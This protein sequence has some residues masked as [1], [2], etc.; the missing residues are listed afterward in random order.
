MPKEGGY[1]LGRPGRGGGGGLLFLWCGGGGWGMPR[2]RPSRSEGYLLGCVG[3]FGNLGLTRGGPSKLWRGKS[4]AS[5]W[6][7][8]LS[9][10]L[11][12]SEALSKPLSKSWSPR[13]SGGPKP[14]S[15]A[16][17][18]SEGPKSELGGSKAEGSKEGGSKV[19]EKGLVAVVGSME[20]SDGSVLTGRFLVTLLASW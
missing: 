11:N 4:S 19:L 12:L 8:G 20:G 7:N 18:L 14:K 16:P 6:R 1:R 17:L 3:A 5:S 15:L 9:N 2:L 13:P 10:P